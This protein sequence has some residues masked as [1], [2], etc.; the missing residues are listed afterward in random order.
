MET[1]N[2][3]QLEIDQEK[4]E[5]NDDTTSAAGSNKAQN[6]LWVTLLVGLAMLLIGVLVGFLTPFTFSMLVPIA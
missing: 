3:E 4:V 6:N 2:T 5:G 1:G